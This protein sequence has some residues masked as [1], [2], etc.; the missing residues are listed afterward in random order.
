MLY[1]KGHFHGK[2]LAS[3]MVVILRKLDLLNYLLHY[4]A[5][6]LLFLLATTIIQ[7]NLR[8]YM[9]STLLLGSTSLFNFAMLDATG[10]FTRNQDNS[11]IF[12]T[13]TSEF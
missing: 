11:S 1:I 10:L 5:S 7:I 2:L 13:E 12:S 4:G 6:T 8:Q 3:Y 9:G